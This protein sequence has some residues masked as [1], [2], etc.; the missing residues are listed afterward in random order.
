MNERNGPTKADQISL[1]PILKIIVGSVTWLLRPRFEMNL[2]YLKYIHM[3][4]VLG[5]KH[6]KEYFFFILVWWYILITTV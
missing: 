5:M 2:S 3:H 4:H 6:A 1:H